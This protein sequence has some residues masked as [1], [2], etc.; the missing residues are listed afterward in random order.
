MG[1]E[2]YLKTNKAA[3]EELRKYAVRTRENLSEKS[4]LELCAYCM[5]DHSGERLGDVIDRIKMYLSSINYSVKG[6]VYRDLADRCE[7]EG[8][9]VFCGWEYLRSEPDMEVDDH[10]RMALKHLSVFAVVVKTPDYFQESESFY[11]KMNDISSEIDAF[12]ETCATCTDF[13]AIGKLAEIGI[14]DNDD[15]EDLLEDDLGTDN[16]VVN[17]EDIDYVYNDNGRECVGRTTATPKCDGG[18]VTTVSDTS[19]P[20]F[21]QT[22]K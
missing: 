17:I 16:G 6:E 18:F 15:Y 11:E 2:K 3:V 19:K 21:E 5:C 14:V 1:Y 22:T 12:V 20:E 8:E 7:E 9:L 10:M 4:V 13:E